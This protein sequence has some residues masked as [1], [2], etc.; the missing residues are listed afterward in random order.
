MKNKNCRNAEKI[1]C[2]LI[3]LTFLAGVA[4]GCRKNKVKNNSDLNYSESYEKPISDFISALNRNDGTRLVKAMGSESMVDDV[5][6]EIKDFAT[7]FEEEYPDIKHEFD[8]K[9]GSDVRFKV[10]FLNDNKCAGYKL[11]YIKNNWSEFYKEEIEDVRMETCNITLKGGADLTSRKVVFYVL[12]LENA[13]Y[14][15]IDEMKYADGGGEWQ[16]DE[17]D[18]IWR[19]AYGDIF[20]FEQLNNYELSRQW[21]SDGTYTWAAN[22]MHYESKAYGETYGEM[23]IDHNEDFLFDVQYYYP[24]GTEVRL[25][26]DYGSSGSLVQF[27]GNTYTI[28]ESGDIIFDA[29]GGMNPGGNRINSSNGKERMTWYFYGE[30]DYRLEDGTPIVKS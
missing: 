16:E 25:L 10:E 13:G 29:F 30:G 11:D 20:D 1:A 26:T 28:Q 4:A 8:E 6:D 2:V 17:N 3:S 27:Y 9:L 12:K 14:V 23:I 15:L 19:L 7:E 21:L 24:D 18:G 5:A 22:D